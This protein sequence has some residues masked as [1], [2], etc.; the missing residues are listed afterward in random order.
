M[1]KELFITHSK[2]GFKPLRCYGFSPS[3]TETDPQKKYKKAKEAVDKGFTSESFQPLSFVDATAWESKGG[4]PGW[5]VPPRSIAV[6]AEDSTTIDAIRVICNKLGIHPPE[7]QTKNGVHLL[8]TDQDSIPGSSRKESKLGCKLTYRAG[9]K[10]YIILPDTDGRRWNVP[11]NGAFPKLP[12]ELKPWDEKNPDDVL[13]VLAWHIGEGYRAKLMQGF[14][15]LDCAFLDY[16][17]DHRMN[18]EQ[19]H[20]A[21][22]TLFLSD[23]D[24]RRTQDMIDRTRGKRD[25]GEKIIG[26]G[27]FIR[28]I[29]DKD[30]KQIRGY[31][32]IFER[33]TK[34][35]NIAQKKLHAI[36]IRDFLYMELPPRENIVDPWLPTQGLIMVYGFR[37]IGK[38]FFI[39]GLALAITSGEKFLKWSVPKPFNVLHIDGEMPAVTVQERYAKL[40]ASQEKEPVAQLKIITPDLQTSGMPNIAHPEGQAMIE[41]H[42]EGIDLVIVDNISTLCRY[43]RE[44]ETESWYPIQEWGLKLRSKRISVVFVHHSGK[45]GFQRGTSSREDVLDTVIN[46][47][48]PADYQPDQGA[49]FEVHFEKA[50]NVHGD[51]VNPFEA[52][53]ET[54]GGNLIWTLKDIEEN[55]TDRIVDLLKEGIPQQEIADILSI[56]KGTVSKHKY[57]AKKAGKWSG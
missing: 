46:L 21:F 19:I 1:N 45:G 20:R 32:N 11:L 5:V 14:E 26:A 56:A 44:N 39:I 53:L 4:W 36:T 47:K 51:D 3:N 31:L 49:R 54:Q 30:L 9:G 6:D 23:Y 7:N 48:R 13:N 22:W 12:D 33:L 42:L 8:F 25:S 57:K 24:E 35:D 2:Y 28:V 52:K 40:I 50:R 38:T 16:L 18:D 43:G 27:T 17:I 41:E 37:G 29:Q 34:K 10:N 55:L 15:D